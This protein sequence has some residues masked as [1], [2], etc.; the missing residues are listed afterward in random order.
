MSRQYYV[1][2]M[3]NKYNTVLYT[4][5][6]NN[7]KRRIYEHKEKLVAGFT[8]KYNLT[9]LVYYEVFDDPET[10]ISREKQ[11]KAGSRQKKTQLID[12]MN[13]EWRDLYEGI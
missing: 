7:L 2:I 9:K 1:Y 10:A 5:I 13:K 4:G 11:I 6:T 12:S 3:T 8:N